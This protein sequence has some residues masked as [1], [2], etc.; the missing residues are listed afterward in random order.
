MIWLTKM[1]I[2][3]MWERDCFK[4]SMQRQL[5]VFY[6]WLQPSLATLFW[7]YGQGVDVTC[8][9]SFHEGHMTYLFITIDDWAE[10]HSL[11]GHVGYLISIFGAP[12]CDWMRDWFSDV[13]G[14]DAFGPDKDL[15]VS[16]RHSFI[17]SSGAFGYTST[18]PKYYHYLFQLD[19]L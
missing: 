13:S 18:S 14:R 8:G 7:R 12:A 11:Y 6:S 4:E 19:D 1:C 9:N 10:S 2:C 3:V 15:P 16:N 5:L 17:H